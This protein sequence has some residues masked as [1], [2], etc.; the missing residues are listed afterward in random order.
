MNSTTAAN[1][2]ILH[3]SW[4]AFAVWLRHDAKLRGMVQPLKQLL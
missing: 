3:M 2:L 4:K 1:E